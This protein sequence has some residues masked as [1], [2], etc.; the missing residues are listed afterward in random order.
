[1]LAAREKPVEDRWPD[2]ADVKPA[3]WARRKANLYGHFVLQNLI[4]NPELDD[5]AIS[6][7][8]PRTGPGLQPNRLFVHSLHNG[9]ILFE[10]SAPLEM[11]GKSTLPSG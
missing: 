8:L 7:G 10:A 2:I 1:V 6:G 5:A 4:I 11:L 3:G 9:G